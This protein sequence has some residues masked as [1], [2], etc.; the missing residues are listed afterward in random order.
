MME[1]A[2][3]AVISRLAYQINCQQKLYDFS[4]ECLFHPGK[5]STSALVCILSST[6]Y[7]AMHAIDH[8][9]IASS[10]QSMPEIRMKGHMVLPLQVALKL[11]RWIVR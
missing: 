4:F 5:R 2:L 6:T 9:A 10:Y 7:I 1:S 3:E 11:A 8:V